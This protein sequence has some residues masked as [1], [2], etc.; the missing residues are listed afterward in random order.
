[1]AYADLFERN[2]GVLT[3]EQQG[4][5]RD[6]CVLIV[7]CG[8]VGGTVATILARSGVGQFLLV[9]PDD[10]EPSNANRQIGCFDHTLG[11]NK[12]EVVGELIRG[13][14]P[15]AR[16]QTVPD[17]IPLD[18]LDGW[19]DAADVVFPAADDYAYSLMVFRRCRALRRTALLVVPSGFW[20][21]VTLVHPDGPSV[22]QLHGVSPELGYD[23]IRSLL[24]SFEGRLG[25]TF[26]TTMGG[27]RPEYF[28]DRVEGDAPM[29]QLCP[30]VWTASSLGALE[31]VKQITGTAR[32]VATPRY[33]LLSR[34]GG[35]RQ[36][37]MAWPTAYNLLARWRRIAWRL[38]RG[39]LGPTFRRLLARGWQ[40]FRRRAGR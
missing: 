21:I 25:E 18:E 20:S 23:E 3:P 2:R 39:P 12:A 7:G 19:V 14:N 24:T 17:R 6:A 31:L 9:D 5:L 13:I 16:V 34:Q 36:R 29:A 10:Y 32:P 28:V 37:H 40:G 15:D 8:G 33:W 35:V 27:W 26:Y 11:R 38:L 4:R 22:E 1:M 30:V